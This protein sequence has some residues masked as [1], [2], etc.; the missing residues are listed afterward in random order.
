[1]KTFER[2]VLQYLKTCIPPSFDPFQFA[3]RANRSVED[4][5]SMGLYHVLKHLEKTD[6]YAR[7]LFIDYSSAFN[8]IIPSKLYHKLKQL[9]LPNP[10]C[11][12]LLDF[13]RCRPQVVK[14]GDFT[15]SV[16]ILNTG[17]PQGCV[18]SPLLYSLFTHDC[19]TQNDYNFMVKFAD[20]TTLEGL[21][22]NDN[23]SRYRED[24]LE[25]VSWCDKNT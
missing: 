4:A 24:V 16:C 21:I 6:S 1:M 9:S 25:L 23:E 11:V 18:L 7:I 19:A 15:S 13:L 10:M 3:Y 22:T 2:L 12:W 20:D 17:T 5:I 8:T 14:V